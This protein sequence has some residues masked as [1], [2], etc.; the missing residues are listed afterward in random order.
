[1]LIW[2]HMGTLE[3]QYKSILLKIVSARLPSCRIYL[4]GSRAKGTQQSGSDIDLALETTK[5]IASD[6]LF[7]LYHDIE[8]S[9]IPVSVDLIDTQTASP[10]LLQEIQ[11][12]GVLWKS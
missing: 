2:T 9:L 6:I 8:E 10:E 11:K 3:E 1:M 7:S 4:F 12:N 5:P